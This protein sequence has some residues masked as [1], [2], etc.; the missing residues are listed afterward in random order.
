M[1]TL[2]TQP[3]I[4]NGTRTDEITS[5]FTLFPANLTFR[6]Y[7][8][9]LTDPSWYMG[10]VNSLIYVVMNTVISITVALPAAYAFSRYNFMGDKPSVILSGFADESA[11]Q[12]TAVQQFCAG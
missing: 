5:T 1:T 12:K 6:N 11:N 4:L 8:V 10:Y 7:A 3:N 9:I 2:A